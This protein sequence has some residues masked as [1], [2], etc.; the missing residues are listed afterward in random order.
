MTFLA[1][2]N[3][4][5]VSILKAEVEVLEAPSDGGKINAVISAQKD[6]N[7]QENGTCRFVFSFSKGSAL[8]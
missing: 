6:G 2:T 3:V 4:D 1:S 8:V 7:L 5:I